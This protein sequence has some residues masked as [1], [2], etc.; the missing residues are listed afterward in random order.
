[1]SENLRKK[2]EE[3]VRYRN[4]LQNMRV[5]SYCWQI[6]YSV[7][8]D[9]LRIGINYE[10]EYGFFCLLLFGRVVFTLFNKGH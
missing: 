9:I 6:P 3:K 10:A 2:V 7:R 5:V 8:P 1:M 4:V